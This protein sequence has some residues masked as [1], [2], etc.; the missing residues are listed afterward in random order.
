MIRALMFLA[1]LA[2]AGAAHAN[3]LG[4]LEARADRARQRAIQR[5]VERLGREHGR[6][7]HRCTR[8]LGARVIVNCI[9]VE[10]ARYALRLADIER[11]HGVSLR[12]A[13]GD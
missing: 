2:G 3:D 11:K 1:A 5:A 4:A 7:V 8:R 13:E 9:R 10:D 12:R 6:H